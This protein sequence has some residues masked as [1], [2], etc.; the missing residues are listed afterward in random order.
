MNNFIRASFLIFLVSRMCFAQWYWQSPLPQGLPLNSVKFI[1]SEIGWAVG[2]YGTIIRTTDGGIT[3]LLQTSETTS[4]LNDVSFTDPNNGTVVGDE[5]TILGTS[6]G[7]TTWTAQISG[8]IHDLNGVSFTDVNVGTAVGTNGTILRTTN[9]GATWSSQT[10]GTTHDLNDVSFTDA[11]TGTV[12]GDEATILRT[13]NGG[14]SWVSQ[15]SGTTNWWRGVC[16]TDANTGTVVGSGGTIIRTTNGGSSWIS[17]STR[18]GNWLESVSFTD[19]NNGTVVGRQGTILRTTNGGTIWSLNVVGTSNYL[20]G[21]SFTDE[22]TGTVVGWEGTILRTTNGGNPPMTFQMSV[23]IA[24][25]WN[26]VSI[27]GLHPINQYV[28]TWWA[29]RDQ[30]ANVFKYADGYLPVTDV[31]FGKGYWMKHSGARVYNT[32]DEWPSDGI[33]I[34]PH[35]PIAAEANWNLIG[36]YELSVT[37][38]FIWTIPFG[39][40]QGSVY[41]YS[42]G[43]QVA[44][45][46][47]PGYGYWIKLSAPGQIIIPEGLA[48]SE[49]V[50]YYPENWGRIVLKDAAELSYTLYVVKEK[51][52]LSQYELPPPPPTGM[53]DIRF[54]SGRIAEDLNNSIKTI[55]MSGITY[56]LTVR[57]ENMDIRLMDESGKMINTKLKSGEDIVISEST[58]Q[59]LM[60]SGKLLP[61]VYSIEQNY[62]NPFNPSTVISWQSPVGSRQTIKVYDILGNEV[63]T[64]ID[65][66]KEAGKY[67]IEFNASELAS[68]VYFYQFRSGGYVIAKKMVLIK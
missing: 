21:V 46:L 26:L 16:F 64:L 12:V 34:V 44:T 3:W 10:S 55:E 45:T 65:E 60:V 13:S 27:P 68:G 24:D 61:T 33:Q 51:V 9:G 52:D 43:Y 25:D 39:L 54:G 56:P 62:P 5:G 19:A 2:N 31:V 57:V 20:Y 7:G 63:E 18:T 49:P 40:Q 59:K 23:S 37:A 67:Q 28:N 32:G 36:G 30:S 58:I 22:N 38:A 8:T 41:K 48:K 11:N 1:S 35:A 50:E 17:Q 4:D 15:S 66:Y 29:Y 6:N 47:E 53:F 14:S 42:G